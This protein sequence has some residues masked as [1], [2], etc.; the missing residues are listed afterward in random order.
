ME[1]NKIQKFKES[2]LKAE[3]DSDEDDLANWH[4]F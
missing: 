4:K 2:K 3:I 1:T